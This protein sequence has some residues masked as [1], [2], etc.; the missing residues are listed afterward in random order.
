M[1][2]IGLSF[3]LMKRG[4]CS[5]PWTILTHMFIHRSIWQ[6]FA[7]ML[8]LWC[9]GFIMQELT[10]NKK[11]IPVYLYGALAGAIA[12]FVAYHLVPGLDPHQPYATYM[13]A[14]SGLMAVAI[15]TTLVS[16]EYRI[17]PLLRGGIPLWALDRSLYYH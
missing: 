14:S 5:R 10:G 13:G 15:S 1:C 7:N 11:I 4:Y 12:F 8:W 6:V 2:L 17:F 16:P 9:F 3:L